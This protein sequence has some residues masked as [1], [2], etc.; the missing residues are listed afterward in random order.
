MTHRNVFVGLVGGLA[1]L[2]P[3][4]AGAPPAVAASAPEKVTVLGG[5]TGGVWYAISV[6]LGKV[7]SDAGTKGSGGLGGANSNIIAVSTGKAE[8]GFIYTITATMAAVPEPPFKEKI[9]NVR[10]LANLWDNVMQIPVARESGVNT[11]ADLKGKPFALQ[12]LSAGTTI[13]FQWVLSAY[14]LSEDDLKVAVRGGTEAGSSA[15]KDRRAVGFMT[16]STYPMGIIEETGAALP[17]KLLP[18]GDEA[19]QKIKRI[20]LGI[21]RAVL[22][23][24]TYKG[25]DKDVPSIGAATIVIVNEK[26]SDDHAYWIT[27]ALVDR[28]DDVRAIHAGLKTLSVKEMASIEGVALHPGAARLYRE[29]GAVK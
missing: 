9:T 10:S 15:M 29:V 20:N 17:I 14:G 7:L 23:A 4:V 3:V 6:G 21:S 26:M 13:L 22:P 1:L 24:G 16:T 27:K 8:A 5:N 18:V 2:V 28:L 25:Q 12:P 19:F 11:V